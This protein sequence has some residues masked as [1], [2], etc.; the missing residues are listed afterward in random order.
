MP[1][2]REG[3]SLG[4]FSTGYRAL[5][6]QI[7]PGVRCKVTLCGCTSMQKKGKHPLNIDRQDK[8]EIAVP[9]P[10]QIPLPIGA[11]LSPRPNVIVLAG[12]NGAPSVLIVQV[13]LADA[14]L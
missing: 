2:A 10:G 8:L 9:D 11:L 1:S 7:I 12:R 4:A 14:L 5:A 6:M 13:I 3:F